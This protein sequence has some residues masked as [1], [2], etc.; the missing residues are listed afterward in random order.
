MGSFIWEN[1]PYL[2]LKVHSGLSYETSCFAG[3]CVRT[4]HYQEEALE[5]LKRSGEAESARLR[6]ELHSTRQRLEKEVATERA[7]SARLRE[8][9]HIANMSLERLTQHFVNMPPSRPIGPTQGKSG[10]FQGRLGPFPGPLGS[11]LQ[12]PSGGPF[13]GQSGGPSPGRGPFQGASP[14]ED[15]G[16]FDVEGFL[17]NLEAS[18]HEQEESEA[19]EELSSD[20]ATESA[21]QRVELLRVS[22]IH[23]LKGAYKQRHHNTSRKE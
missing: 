17:A 20:V 4:V 13:P 2:C 21:G 15:E 10:G 23:Q 8:R 5:E 19:L 14:P 6:E 3:Q 9:V 11:H 22:S 16:H 12:G 18:V 1:H 7:E